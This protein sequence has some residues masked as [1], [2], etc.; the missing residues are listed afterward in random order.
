MMMMMMMRRRRRNDDSGYYDQDVDNDDQHDE[1][2]Y[3]DV[4]LVVIR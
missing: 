4:N 3:D 2:G 1:I